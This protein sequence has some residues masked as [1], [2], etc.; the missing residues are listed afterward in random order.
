MSRVS[1]FILAAIAGALIVAGTGAVGASAIP[2]TVISWHVVNQVLAESGPSPDSFTSVAALT[3]TSAWAFE[4][5]ASKTTPIVAWRLKG[6]TWS[7]VTFPEGFGTSAGVVRATPTTAYV[8][9]SRGALFISVGTK[10][11]LVS[12]FVDITNIASTGAGDV[13]VTG[14]RT[15]AK[16]SGGLWHLD[17]GVWSQRSTHFYGWIDAVSDTAIFSTTDTAVEEFNGS[18][19]KATSLVA[20]LPAKQPLCQD[21]GLTSIEALT[22]SDLWVTAAGNCQDFSGPFRLLHFVNSRWTIAADREVARGAPYP[23]GDGSLWIPTRAFAC[24]GCTQMLHLAAGQLTQVPLP[25]QKQ[26]GVAI[27]AI[28]TP[29][30]STSSI[31]VG[32]TLKGNDFQDSRGVILRWGT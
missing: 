4:T 6:S 32:W 25:L 29:P 2:R 20:L 8:A 3:P 9:T 14:R 21:P 27:V 7:K 23:A 28:A 12:K 11:K 31:A 26:G 1:K 5:T 15:T 13:W 22:P 16:T 19:W 24:T 30:G 18:I 17:H 10:W